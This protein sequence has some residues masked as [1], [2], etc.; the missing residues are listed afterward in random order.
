M[1]GT[2]ALC[3]D[4]FVAVKAKSPSYALSLPAT[5]SITANPNPIQV[6]DGTGLGITTLS[7]TST[8]T[9]TVEVHISSPS[10]SLFAS[11]GPS[12]SSTTGKWVGQG[13][14]FFLQDVSGGL[15]L[16]SANTIAT[17]AVGLTTAGCAPGTQWTTPDAHNDISNTN[18][19][20]VGI[21][22]TPNLFAKLHVF[23]PPFAG[24]DIQSSNAAGWAR[25]RLVTGTHAYGWFTGD[26]TQADAPNK[27]GLYDYTA[28]AFRMMI[29]SSGNVGIGTTGP[30]TKLHVVKP[31]TT[32]GGGGTSLPDTGWGVYKSDMQLLLDTGG[33]RTMNRGGGIGF[34]NGDG[35]VLGAIKG[36]ATNSTAGQFGGY[37]GF[38]TTSSNS[39]GST[40]GYERMRIDENG[41]VGIGTNA[42]TTKLDVAGQIRSST[43]GFK[44]PDGTVQT[45]AATGGGGGAVDSVF[46]RTGAVVTGN[47][48]YTWAQINKSSSSL[49]DIQTRSA[50]DLN[51]G[52]VPIARLGVSGIPDATTFLRGDNTWATV[53]GGPSQWTTTSGTNNI[54]YNSGNVGIGTTT[55]GTQLHIVRPVIG[56][57]VTV[58]NTER[59]LILV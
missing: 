56:Q 3:W 28:N 14:Q 1:I 30:G 43:G 57:A 35:F 16:T 59:P 52:T 2:G 54:S 27:I 11:S 41:N 46:G 48:D 13:T 10:G 31:Y 15:P 44:F 21:G 4:S 33:T 8:G 42:P 6:C 45:T 26:S 53:P 22:T 37:L 29:D 32:D 25:L 24:I 20:N 38:Y 49:A 55:P 18:T 7:W 58:D 36:A 51:A 34:S 12:G 47:N 19:G 23:Q 40:N 17:V 9:S 50:G 5:G 39:G